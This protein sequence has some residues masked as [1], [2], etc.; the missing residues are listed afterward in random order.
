MDRGLYLFVDL[1]KTRELIPKTREMS[2]DVHAAPHDEL[3]KD[4]GSDVTNEG[5]TSMG[6]TLR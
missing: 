2:N 3:Y 6:N 1:T 5:K 4:Y